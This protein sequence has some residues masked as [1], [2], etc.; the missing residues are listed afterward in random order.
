MNDIIVKPSRDL[1]NYNMLFEHRYNVLK[2]IDED[3]KIPYQKKYKLLKY[4][5][6]LERYMHNLLCKILYDEFNKE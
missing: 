3:K 5:I 1:N 4:A 2:L 6:D